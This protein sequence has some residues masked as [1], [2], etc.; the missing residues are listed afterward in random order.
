MRDG[1]GC[2]PQFKKQDSKQTNKQLS[3]SQTDTV[4]LSVLLA[5][6]S[7]IPQA[8]SK[9]L[10]NHITELLFVFCFW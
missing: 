1:A 8:S 4:T 9:T 3:L 10:L 6:L 7:P 5:L 2:S